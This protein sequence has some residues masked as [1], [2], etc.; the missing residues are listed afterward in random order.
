M[1]LF[2]PIEERNIP[3]LEHLEEL[4]ARLIKSVVALILAILGA[5]FLSPYAIDLML[6]PIQE[7]GLIPKHHDT[8]RIV[9]GEDG[10][11]RLGNLGD[12]IAENPEEE[13]KSLAGRRL[14]RIEFLAEGADLPFATLQSV[15]RSGIVY[16]RP[17]DPFIVRIKTALVLGIMLALPYLIYQV[18]AFVAPGLTDRERRAVVPL[19]GGALFLFPAGVAFAYFMLKY[20][21]L[22][23]ASYASEQAYLFHDIRAYL[24]LAL[25]T[26]LV[27]GAVFE[28]PVVVLLLTRLGVITPQQLA[29]KRKYVFVGLVILCALV[30][31]TGD[32]FTLMAMS[33]PLYGLFELSLIL[34][35]MMV[36]GKNPPGPETPER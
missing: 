24:S 15:D 23:F 9:V 30:T 4:R 7:S 16:I 34:G 28:L 33:F 31:P 20:A 29:A 35:R 5:Y 21:L 3:L 10:V 27:F 1:G 36:P 6:L 14:G 22:F 12:L 17:M 11:F 13:N 32:P 8:A 25:T 2:S 26:M 18:W 19:F